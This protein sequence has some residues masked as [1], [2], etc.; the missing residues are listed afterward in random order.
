MTMAAPGYRTRIITF[1]AEGSRRYAGCHR[2]Q[3][4]GVERSLTLTK[5]Q[6]KSFGGITSLVSCGQSGQNARSARSIR[7]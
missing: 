5:R 3:R 2:L 7:T 6:S 4:D 1:S